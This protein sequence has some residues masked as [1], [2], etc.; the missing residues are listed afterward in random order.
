MELCA[1]GKNY[2]HN[3]TNRMEVYMTNQLQNTREE[4][5]QIYNVDGKSLP[6]VEFRINFNVITNYFG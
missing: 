2:I 3:R 6:L 5:L 1:L 4:Y